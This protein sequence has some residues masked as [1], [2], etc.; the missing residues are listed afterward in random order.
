MQ[1]RAEREARRRRLAEAAAAGEEKEVEREQELGTVATAAGATRGEDVPVT[2]MPPQMLQAQRESPTS[3]PV[4][5]PLPT[6]TPTP[7]GGAVYTVSVPTT[8]DDFAWY[9]AT[10]VAHTYETLDT[11]R[12]ANVWNYPATPEDRAR[13]EVFRNLWE[14]GFYMGGG[15]KFGGDWLVYPGMDSFFVSL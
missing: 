1:K 7:T 5:S 12:A 4:S 15:S 9:D 11:A 6:A 3:E 10:A 8:S 2:Q 14:K 13:C